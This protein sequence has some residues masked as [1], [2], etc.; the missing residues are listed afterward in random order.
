M[1]E[2]RASAGTVDLERL[3]PNVLATDKELRDEIAAAGLMDLLRGRENAGSRLAKIKTLLEMSG[4]EVF[5]EQFPLG[6]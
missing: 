6:E 4:K 5:L 1:H 3:D 2:Q